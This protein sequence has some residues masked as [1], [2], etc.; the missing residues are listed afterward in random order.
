MKR[1]TLHNRTE[2]LPALQ[3]RSVTPVRQIARAE[4]ELRF[5]QRTTRSRRFPVEESLARSTP[6]PPW[7]G[8]FLDIEV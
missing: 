7:R 4:P 3:R 6:E 8:H 1:L 5:Q 2:I